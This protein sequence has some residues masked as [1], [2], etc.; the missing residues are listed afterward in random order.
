MKNILNIKLINDL[1]SLIEEN[2]LS[3][4]KTTFIN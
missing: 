3:P 1:V 2:R 4:R